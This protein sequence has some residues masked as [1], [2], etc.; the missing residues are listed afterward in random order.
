MI[1]ALKAH[2]GWLVH[3][4][5]LARNPLRRPIDRVAAAISVLLLLVALVAVPATAVFGK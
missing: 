1:A 4:L 3:A 2:A 5:G